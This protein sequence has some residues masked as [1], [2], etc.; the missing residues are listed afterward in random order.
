[1]FDASEFSLLLINFYYT[2]IAKVVAL[3][4]LLHFCIGFVMYIHQ[5]LFLCCIDLGIL[6]YRS[7]QYHNSDSY[8][9]FSTLK[10][11]AKVV[12]LFQS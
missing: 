9:C 11:I 4:L 5:Q 8:H 3:N 1:M 7:F 12:V 2:E 10:A 6:S